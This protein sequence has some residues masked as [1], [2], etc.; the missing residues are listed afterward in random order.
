MSSALAACGREVCLSNGQE[1]GHLSPP[2]HVNIQS[3]SAGGHL[4]SGV[5]MVT[6]DLAAQRGAVD[7]RDTVCGCVLLTVVVLHGQRKPRKALPA[8]SLTMAP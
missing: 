2:A 5:E 8:A 4:K 3:V 1:G 6:S 7:P